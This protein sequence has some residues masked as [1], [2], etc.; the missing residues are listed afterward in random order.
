MNEVDGGKQES[1]SDRANSRMNDWIGVLVALAATLMAIGNIKDGNVGQAMSK[2]QAKAVDAWSYYQAKSTK[3]VIAEN[4][5]AQL[6]VQVDTVATSGAARQ[7]LEEQAAHYADEARRY[8]REKDEIKK[9]AEG[10]EAEYERLN[11]FDDQ[12]DM[13]EAAFTVAIALGGITALTR[14]KL[15][16]AGATFLVSAGI[17]FEAAGFAGWNLHPEWLA[18]L[19][20]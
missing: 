9:Q 10:F 2:A 19:L 4:T 8:D 1:A 6:R 20:G 7:K 13:A 16:L 14:H 3:Q 12:F 15:L 5:A 11:V 18:R 17:A